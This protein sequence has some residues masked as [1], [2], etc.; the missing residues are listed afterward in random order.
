MFC[1]YPATLA[2]IVAVLRVVQLPVLLIAASQTAT[3]RK[4]AIDKFATDDKFK[5]LVTTYASGGTGL[6]LQQACFNIHLL[7][8]PWNDGTTQQ[9]IGRVR[10]LGNKAKKV[11]VYQY[12]TEGGFDDD[13]IM[14][15]IK[16]AVPEAVAQY[17]RVVTTSEDMIDEGDLMVGHRVLREGEVVVLQDES[18]LLPGEKLMEIKDVF[19][20]ILSKQKG[21][22]VEVRTGERE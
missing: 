8:H 6:N 9:A 2:L 20:H 3:E 18:Q 19:R 10:R 13:R 7:E 21:R 15:A 17:S 12:F 16:K 5:I 4:A 11:N 22:V 14:S 1:I